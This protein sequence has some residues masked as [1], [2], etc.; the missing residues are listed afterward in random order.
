MGRIRQHDCLKWGAK[1]SSLGSLCTKAVSIFEAIL[2]FYS[3]MNVK[4]KIQSLPSP[5]TLRAGDQRIGISRRYQICKISRPKRLS[6][7]SAGLPRQLGSLKQLMLYGLKDLREMPD[8]IGLT[9]LERLSIFCCHQLQALPIG[10]LGALKQLTL[11]RLNELREIPDPIGL[12]E[13]ERLTIEYCDMLNRLPMRVG[14][15]RALKELTLHVHV[16]DLDEY[17]P[18]LGKLSTTLRT[19]DIVASNCGLLGD[20]GGGF[21]AYLAP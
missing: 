7:G 4:D 1:C 9:S 11:C 17:L 2:E 6:Q 13:L 16:E 19:L 20:Y 15:L 21:L 18:T 3:L 5:S 14:E 12:T 8:P 10:E